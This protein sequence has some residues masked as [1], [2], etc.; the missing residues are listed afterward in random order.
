MAARHTPEQ[1]IIETNY[2]PY[3]EP[4]QEAYGNCGIC[5]GSGVESEWDNNIRREFPCGNCGGDGLSTLVT[6]DTRGNALRPEMEIQ[7][8][9]L[10]VGERYLFKLKHWK[11]FMVVR[12]DF[13]S[14]SYIITN[15]LE[16]DT[17]H[18]IRI[19]NSLYTFEEI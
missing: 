16:R 9:D 3:A 14:Q 6:P 8:K 18:C 5:F 7:A 15:I 17:E 2:P 4:T 12:V 13:V 19:D 11:L 10:V 1:E